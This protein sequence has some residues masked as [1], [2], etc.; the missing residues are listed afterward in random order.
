MSW[1]CRENRKRYTV[2]STRIAL[3]AGTL[4]TRAQIARK[5]LRVAYKLRCAAFETLNIAR[6]YS[7]TLIGTADAP[8]GDKGANIVFE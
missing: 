2:R 6:D 5:I 1:R 7:W 3:P 8:C 4:F